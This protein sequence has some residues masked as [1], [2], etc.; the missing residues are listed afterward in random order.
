[1]F[2]YSVVY[3]LAD[4]SGA[5]VLISRVTWVSNYMTFGAIDYCALTFEHSLSLSTFT[6]SILQ[7]FA[8]AILTGVST[9][10]SSLY[11]LQ[12]LSRLSCRICASKCKQTSDMQLAVTAKLHL[13]YNQTL[14]FVAG[15][16]LQRVRYCNRSIVTVLGVYSSTMS[17]TSS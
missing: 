6:Y 11:A 2:Y 15:N 16:F 8:S 4:F 12:V 5:M 3:L 10:A 1:M 17:S 14:S 13:L 7:A 9:T